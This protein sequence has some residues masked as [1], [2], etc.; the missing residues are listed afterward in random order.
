M[1]LVPLLPLNTKYLVAMVIS[2][3]GTNTGEFNVYK[4]SVK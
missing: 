3:G 2:N 1:L 4:N